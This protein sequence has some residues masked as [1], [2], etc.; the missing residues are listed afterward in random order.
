MKSRVFFTLFLCAGYFW[1]VFLFCSSLICLFLCRIQPTPPPLHLAKFFPPAG[2]PSPSGKDFSSDPQRPCAVLCVPTSLC[3][4]E[5]PGPLL[6][7]LV[8]ETFY[9]CL[10]SCPPLLLPFDKVF[11]RFPSQRALSVHGVLFRLRVP[12]LLSSRSRDFLLILSV[13][14]RLPGS[15]WIR[16]FLSSYSP[17]PQG[18]TFPAFSCAIAMLDVFYSSTLVPS[19]TTLL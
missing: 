17:L 8:S 16:I 11:Y 4:L 12:H 15:C 9:N 1:L 5:S 10:A 6:N 3:P 2:L 19:P 7:L 18:L 13:S 14:L